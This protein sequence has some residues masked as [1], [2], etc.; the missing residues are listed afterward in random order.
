MMKV[1]ECLHV[2]PPVLFHKNDI[3]P[4]IRLRHAQEPEPVTKNNLAKAHQ[5]VFHVQRYFIE[6]CPK[7]IVYSMGSKYS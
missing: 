2:L 6:T 5:V 4:T 7:D 1:T 3:A